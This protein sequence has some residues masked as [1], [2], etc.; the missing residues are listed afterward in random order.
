MKN[1]LKVQMTTESS[2]NVK[3]IILFHK[4]LKY[5][6]EGKYSSIHCFK[7]KT[8]SKDEDKDSEKSKSSS[9]DKSDDTKS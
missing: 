8:S 7:G 1:G 5:R 6:V 4:A 9:E 3:K 2:N